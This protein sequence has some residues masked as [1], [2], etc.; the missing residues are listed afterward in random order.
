MRPS[1]GL[2]L[3]GL[4][5]E[6]FVNFWAKVDKT[7]GPKFKGTKCWLWTA[8]AARGYSMWALPK[9]ITD[10]RLDVRLGHQV[11]YALTRGPID[12]GSVFVQ[13]CETP[14][15]IRHWTPFSQAKARQ[16]T[17][18]RRARAMKPVDEIRA[19]R[20][21]GASCAEIAEEFKSSGLS[22]EQV[23][24]IALNKQAVDPKYKPH[25]PK[26]RRV[27]HPELVRFSPAVIK[28]MKRAFKAGHS[29]K[30]IAEV[31]GGP[32]A[33][34]WEAIHGP[35][36]ISRRPASA[37]RRKRSNAAR[38]G[39]VYGYAK[40]RAERDGWPKQACKACKAAAAERSREE[41]ARGRAAA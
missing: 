4:D 38:H 20:R 35:S 33:T 6:V 7:T 14:L 3:S 17:A 41:Y 29:I 19:R 9:S 37:K 27:E 36:S 26:G 23:R 30:D 18:L 22:H 40:H 1:K 5:P 39:T 11:A 12:A 25:P 10:G 13:D 21:Q 16:V 24:E 34:V 8:Q 2:D 31:A 32:Y 28:E 15:C